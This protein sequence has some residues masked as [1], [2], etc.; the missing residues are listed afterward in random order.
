MGKVGVTIVAIELW[1]PNAAVLK[2]EVWRLLVAKILHRATLYVPLKNPTM[3]SLC[4]D[5][6]HEL[7]KSLRPHSL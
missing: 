7:Q 6:W 1:H 4:V 5:V 3:P 2:N